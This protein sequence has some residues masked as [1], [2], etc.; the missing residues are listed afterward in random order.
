MNRSMLPQD[1]ALKLLQRLAGDDAFRER[2][3]A[4]PAAALGEVGVAADQLAALGKHC[5]KRQKLAPKAHF[6]SLLQDTS[7]TQFTEA[8]SM[9]VQE[10]RVD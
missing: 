2:Y 9:H 3:E 1:I 7:S 4:D 8:M 5:A 10:L 6:A